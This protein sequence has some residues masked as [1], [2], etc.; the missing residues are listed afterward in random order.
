[1]INPGTVWRSV[2]SAG[3]SD[4]SDLG[5]GPSVHHILAVKPR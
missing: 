5:S 3:V 2:K 1:M 4:K